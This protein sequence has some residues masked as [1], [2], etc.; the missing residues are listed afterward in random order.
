MQLH[1]VAT[2]GSAYQTGADIWIFLVERANVSWVFV[3]VNYSLMVREHTIGSL[4]E[5]NLPLN[6]VGENMW[7]EGE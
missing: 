3:V 2:C 4:G 5:H 6:S 1:D 7:L